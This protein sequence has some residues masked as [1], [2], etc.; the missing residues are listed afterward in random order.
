MSVLEF[1]ILPDGGMW[2]PRSEALAGKKIVA[3]T[4]EQCFRRPPDRRVSKW[5]RMLAAF[6]SVG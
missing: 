6:G 2:R 3:G 5:D 1:R 4:E